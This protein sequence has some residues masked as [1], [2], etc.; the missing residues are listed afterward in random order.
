[1][2]PLQIRPIPPPGVRSIA[3][4]RRRQ[5]GDTR[6]YAVTR[7][8]KRRNT[9]QSVNFAHRKLALSQDLTNLRRIL[10]SDTARS[11]AWREEDLSC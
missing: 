7:L 6:N 2:C 5:V 10:R 3:R 4:L 1:M 9:M 11:Q 8:S